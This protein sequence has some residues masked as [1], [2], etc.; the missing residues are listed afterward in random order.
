[1]TDM[2]EQE[3]YP[4]GMGHPESVATSSEGLKALMANARTAD[5]RHVGAIRQPF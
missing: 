1:M 3:E 4:D 2:V 5:I